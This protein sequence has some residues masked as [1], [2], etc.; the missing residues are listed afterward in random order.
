[1]GYSSLVVETGSMSGTIEE[2]DVI[3]IKDTGDYKIGDIITF[4]KE[5]EKIPTTHR[6]VNIDDDGGFVTRGDANNSEDI[7]N[8][9]EDEICGEVVLTMH[10]L[11]L[12][13]GWVG[14]G[15]GYIYILGFLLIVGL[16]IFL[17]K[18]E[19]IIFVGDDDGDGDKNQSTEEDE[20]DK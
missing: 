2:G 19:K 12:L 7:H 6:I 14:K 11:G 18:D 3:I 15:G 10:K 1:M 20:K 4:F 17:I 8:V 5:G 9:Y 16:G 13:I